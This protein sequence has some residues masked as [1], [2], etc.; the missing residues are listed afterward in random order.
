MSSI[1]RTVWIGSF[2]VSAV[3]ALVTTATSLGYDKYSD[4]CQN[5]HGSFLGGTSPQGTI[6]PE[7]NKH[8][9]H[10][11]SLYMATK[12][13]LC[14]T[15]SGYSNVYMGSSNG[16]SLNPGL[17]CNGCHGHDY[18]GSV[19]VSGAG[20]RKHHASAGVSVCADCHTNDPIPLGEN[21]KPTY[22]GT[23]DTKCND[24]C[25]AAPGFKENWSVGD[26]VGLDNDGDLLYDGADPDCQPCPAADLTGDCQVNA[27]DVAILLGAWGGTGA[28]DLNGDGSVN[29]A[30]LSILLGAW[31]T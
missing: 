17:G 23:T 13:N 12:C 11:G 10:R 22:Y 3:A 20:L 5:C 7:Q 4:G 16:T 28:A 8:Q 2:T 9:M 31:G 18:G 1:A 6:F 15:G 24:P 19:G 21:V 27:A 14:H 26:T 29:A 30:D 25:N